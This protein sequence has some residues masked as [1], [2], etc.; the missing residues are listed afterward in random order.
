MS[1]RLI[2][3]PLALAGAFILSGC[4]KQAPAT[5]AETAAVSAA[6]PAA[7]KVRVRACDM[8]TEAEM[9]AIL[10]G[11]VA[12]APGGN[13]RPPAQTECVYSS[14]D[15]PA[16]IWEPQSYADTQAVAGPY[17]EIQVD[18]GGGDTQSL[19]TAA[20][21]INKPAPTVG[22]DP[23]AG[24]GDRAYQVIPTQIFI[25]VNGDLMMIR[26]APRADDVIAKARRIFE[27]A[28]GRL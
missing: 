15:G 18:W 21:L 12:A 28:K 1:S 7:T 2:A 13:E 5:D 20:G 24:L 23:L 8:V 19:D 27:T 11:A 22:V 9:S 16:P 6:A 17:A 14:I 26:F 10:G 4:S 3:L 25:S